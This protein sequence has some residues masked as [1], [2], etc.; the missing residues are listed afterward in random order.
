MAAQ[1]VGVGLP[2]LTEPIIEL[3]SAE[4]AQLLSWTKYLLGPQLDRVSPLINQRIKLETERR[5]LKPARERDDFTWMGLGGPKQEHRLNNWCPWI[6]SDLLVTNLILEDNPKL[7]I[8][9]TVRITKIGEKKF[10]DPAL[11]ETARYK[12]QALLRICARIRFLLGA[13]RKDSRCPGG[14]PAAFNV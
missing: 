4:T 12:G 7:R 8:A 14:T 11:L 6:N 3:F 10:T 1:K 5:M 13:A 9:E 2:D